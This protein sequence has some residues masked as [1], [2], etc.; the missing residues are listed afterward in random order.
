MKKILSLLAVF[1]LGMNIFLGPQGGQVNGSVG[2]NFPDGQ[3]GQPGFP[4]SNGNNDQNGGN[5]PNG[6]NGFFGPNGNNGSNRPNGR[7]GQNGNNRAPG[8]IWNNQDGNFNFQSPVNGNSAYAFLAPQFP[9]ANN[10]NL[11]PNSPNNPANAVDYKF[12]PCW[13]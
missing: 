10:P 1:G 4:G 2:L 9:G 11:N 12:P 3:N 6:G 7:R 5:G 8:Q 13:L